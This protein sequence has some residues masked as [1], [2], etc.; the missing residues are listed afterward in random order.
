MNVKYLN[1][2]INAT[3][4][5][6]KDYQIESKIGKPYLKDVYYK[7]PTVAILLGITGELKG[8][9][10]F[11]IEEPSAKYVTSKMMMGLEVAELNDMAK[12]AL[13]ELCNMILGNAAT[14]FSQEKIAIDITPPTLTAGVDMRFSVVNNQLVSIP[15]VFGDYT[16]EIDVAIKENKGD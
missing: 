6:L 7:G 5:V 1:P 3:Q 10:I 9:V 15:I 11:S 13:S 16:L 8:Q 12:S 2:F 4:K 14:L